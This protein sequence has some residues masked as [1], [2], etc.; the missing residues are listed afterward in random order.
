MM[1]PQTT[2]EELAGVYC[3]VLEQIKVR[4]SMVQSV[5]TGELNTG[6]ELHNYEIAAMNLRK[7]LELLAF[8]SLC[9]NREAYAKV[10]ADFA[11]HWNAKK[12]LR[13]L[14]KIHPEFYP[15]P[16]VLQVLDP[17]PPRHLHF[18]YISE[19][20][21][22][23]AEF[24]DLYDLCSQIIHTP[25]PFSPVRTIDFRRSVAD[26]VNR[27]ERL[28]RLHQ[29]KLAGTPQTWLAELSAQG[30]GRAHAYVA[31]PTGT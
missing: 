15:K 17:G 22:T 5:V 24:V 14:E 19:G 8:G 10:H 30:D 12:L 18:D 7:A 13:K 1:S 23:Q 3:A 6:V 25:N 29:M 21:L 2:V 20:F 11:T 9:A 26:W 4:L 27:I 31:K 16:V 28:L